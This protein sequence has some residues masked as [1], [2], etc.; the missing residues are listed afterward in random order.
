LRLSATLRY[1]IQG[2]GQVIVARDVEDGLCHQVQSSGLGA[3]KHNTVLMGWPEGYSD[4]ER[5]DTDGA[6][7]RSA[8]LFVST[9]RNATANQLA[10]IVPRNIHLFPTFEDTLAGTIDVWWIVHDGGMLLLLSFLMKQVRVWR[11]YWL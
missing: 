3:L 11:L 8:Q 9:L 1:G 6:V 2:F 5:E 10:V 4:K 7:A